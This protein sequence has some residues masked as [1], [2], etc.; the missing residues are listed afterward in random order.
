MKWSDSISTAPNGPHLYTRK[1]TI[2]NR[3]LETESHQL[4][5]CRTR[6]LQHISL[7][8]N[9]QDLTIDCPNHERTIDKISAPEV[10]G[11]LLGTVQSL[12]IR[13][14]FCSPPALIS[15]VASFQRLERLN[16]EGIWFETAEIPRPLSERHTFK[17]AFHWTDWDDSSEDFVSLLAEHD[18]QYHEMLVNGEWWL[19]D[20]T[21]NRCLAKC[22]DHLRSFE[23]LWSESS[24]ENASSSIKLNCFVHFSFQASHRLGSKRWSSVTYETFRSGLPL[25]GPRSFHPQNSSLRLHRRNYPK[26][27]SI[28]PY[29]PPATSWMKL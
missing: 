6:F 11:R 19:Q 8:H 13:G 7:F 10:F 4:P 14:A 16:L 12:S 21:W 24:C 17:G 9:L 27:R 2:S 1:L 5:E 15:L 20:T 3:H 28:P 22:A 25:S 18:L 26:S 29:S 23:I